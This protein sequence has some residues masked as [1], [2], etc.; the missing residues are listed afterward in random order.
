[1]KNKNFK[2][3]LTAYFF[4]A[5]AFILL[6]I[7]TLYPIV[8]SVFLSF[9]NYDAISSDNMGQL[10][11]PKWVGFENF[12]KITKDPIFYISLKNSLVYLVVVPIIQIFSLLLA[13]LVNRKLKGITFFRTLY[14]VPV[15]TS[16][17]IVGI[18]FKWLFNS[19]GLINFFLTKVMPYGFAGINWLTDKNMALISVMSVTIWQGLGYYMVLY[20]AGLQGIPGE[21]E[22]AARLDG[23]NKTQVFLKITIPL[24]KPFI[25]LCSIISC[26]SALKVFTEIFVLTN[27]GPQFG[28]MTML[29]YIYTKAFVD[30]EL[31]YSC[32]LAVILALFISIISYINF[33][34]FKE[35][36][37]VYY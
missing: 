20:L 22:E 33:K 5:P 16:M 18:S 17:V 35:G 13:V 3:A 30:F 1:M 8:Y 29:Y 12:Q 11:S 2:K 26:I 31:G 15:I 7:F 14:Y 21:Y 9:N 27:G 19:T 32:A 23:A 36:G 28:T 4:L 24:L 6:I 25:A 34:F 10:L 37:I